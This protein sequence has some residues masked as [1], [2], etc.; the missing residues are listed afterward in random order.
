[1]NGQKTSSKI[2]INFFLSFLS[3][4]VYRWA[5]Q[6]QEFRDKDH[7]IPGFSLV[8]LNFGHVWSKTVTEDKALDSILMDWYDEVF[9]LG[10]QLTKMLNP[11]QISNSHPF[12]LVLSLF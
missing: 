3:K 5:D 2:K 6:C 4:H 12:I 1:M 11:C 9:Y 10:L 7:R 8:G